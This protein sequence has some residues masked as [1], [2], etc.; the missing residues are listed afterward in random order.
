VT[1]NNSPTQ[2]DKYITLHTILQVGV[3]ALDNL[4]IINQ[5][6]IP[7]DVTFQIIFKKLIITTPIHNTKTIEDQL[8]NLSQKIE[9]L[10]FPPPPSIHR[11][12][13]PQPPKTQ[14][15]TTLTNRKHYPNTQNPL[16][17][18]H[19]SQLTFIFKS[20]PLINDQN[21]STQITNNINNTLALAKSNIKISGI[22][23]SLTGNCILMV[24]E[25]H[26]ATN[27]KPYA[28][29]ITHLLTKKTQ[30]IKTVNEDKP[31]PRVVIDG[32]DMG[33][34]TW[35]DNPSPYSI[36]HI[37]NMLKTDNP[38]FTDIK[39]K[40]EPR[41]ICGRDTINTKRHSSLVIPSMKNQ[42][43]KQCS[44]TNS[45]SAGDTQCESRCKGN[46]NSLDEQLFSQD[47]V[48]GNPK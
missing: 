36:E 17:R 47:L 12:Y 37:L 39:L 20:P 15:T 46:P 14:Q 31:W 32:V 30:Q 40:E 21:E 13:N 19:P 45:F 9:T 34:Q 29:S 7:K 3:V 41:W 27:L 22:T 4:D 2:G 1:P 11:T 16:A 24:H 33:I 48:R 38:W 23:W 6:E 35:D 5:E 26:T 18:H 10:T 28:E 8:D 44:T 43:K 42:H 25:G